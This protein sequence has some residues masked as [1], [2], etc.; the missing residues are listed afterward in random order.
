MIK[1]QLTTNK[2][3][4]VNLHEASESGGFRQGFNF[5]GALHGGKEFIYYGLVVWH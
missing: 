1:K 3:T 2:L 4:K 5:I